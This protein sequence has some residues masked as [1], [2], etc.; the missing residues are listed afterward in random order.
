MNTCFLFHYIKRLIRHIPEKHFKMVR[1]YG[2]YARHRESD[3]KLCKAIPEFKQAFYLSLTKWRNSIAYSF[4]YDPLK[5]S[6]GNQMSL[7]ELF[8]NH[9]PVPL[10]DLYRKA[11]EKLRLLISS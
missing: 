8:H 2:I 11:V 7:L 3:K 10:D 1:Y 5:C 9:K 4:G 6:C